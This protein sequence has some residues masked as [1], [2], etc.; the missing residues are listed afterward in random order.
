MTPQLRMR[1]PTLEGLP[2]LDVPQ[3]YRLERARAEDAQGVGA[4]VGAAFEEPWGEEWALKTLFGDPNVDSVLV[5]RA[6]DGTVAATASARSILDQP[7]VGYVH[8]V[9]THPEHAGRALGYLATL[10]VLHEFVRLGKS[11]AVLDTDDH[12]IP[13]IRTYLKLGFEPWM[14]DPSH[15]GRWAAIGLG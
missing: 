4:C 10:A 5:I 13:A 9:A 11:S 15:E 3:G 8:F 12:R 2:A 14:T 7:E 1:R 6:E